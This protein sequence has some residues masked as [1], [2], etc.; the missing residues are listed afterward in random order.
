[1]VHKVMEISHF[2]S[3]HPHLFRFFLR[4]ASRSKPLDLMRHRR[5]EPTTWWTPLRPVVL[6][7]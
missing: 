6:T 4:K 5:V 3:L 1:M 2:N 7:G